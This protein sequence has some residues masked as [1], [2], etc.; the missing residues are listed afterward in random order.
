M[1]ATFW[2]FNIKLWSSISLHYHCT[3]PFFQTYVEEAKFVGSVR[4]ADYQSLDISNVYITAGNRN[5]CEE[6]KLP[7]RGRGIPRIQR[8]QIRALLYSYQLLPEFSHSDYHLKGWKG[9]A[10]TRNTQNGLIRHWMVERI[11][12]LSLRVDQTCVKEKAQS[13]YAQDDIEMLCKSWSRICHFR[14]QSN[15]A[16]VFQPRSKSTIELV[17]CRL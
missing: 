9:A 11:W 15:A 4:R 5:C 17:A 10:H 14:L 6:R 13:I 2:Y 12:M 8:T 1:L 16:D 7:H 3:S